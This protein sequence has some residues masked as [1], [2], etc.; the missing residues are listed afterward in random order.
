MGPDDDH[1]LAAVGFGR[2]MAVAVEAAAGVAVSFARDR[3]LHPFVRYVEPV[4]MGWARVGVVGES[5]GGGV[6]EGAAALP[7]DTQAL[8]AV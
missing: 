7:V 6:R 2:E 3:Q 1:V 5:G 8:L 4:P